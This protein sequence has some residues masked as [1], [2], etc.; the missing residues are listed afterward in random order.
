MDRSVRVRFSDSIDVEATEPHEDSWLVEASA[1]LAHPDASGL[2]TFLRRL[3]SDEAMGR[4][5]FRPLCRL[6]RL[7]EDFSSRYEAVDEAIALLRDELSSVHARRARGIVASA[8]LGQVGEF[9]D[10]TLDFLLQH[11]ELVETDDLVQGAERIGR[12][13]WSRE[14]T[15]RPR[16]LGVVD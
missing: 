11:L 2:R 4:W 13:V 9:N 7:V 10:A 1:D 8:A 6:H 16:P 5:T 12:A 3:G 14:P 15:N